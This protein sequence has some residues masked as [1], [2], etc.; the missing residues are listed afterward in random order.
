MER[1]VWQ[2]G[3][4]YLLCSGLRE[5]WLVTDD[6]A[7]VFQGVCDCAQERGVCPGGAEPGHP[8]LESPVRGLNEASALDEDHEAA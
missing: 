2:T 7:E 5:H 1:I 3:A 6:G 8:P 4:A